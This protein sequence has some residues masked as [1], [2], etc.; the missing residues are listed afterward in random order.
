MYMYTRAKISSLFGIMVSFIVHC[1]QMA[2]IGRHTTVLAMILT[3]Q[4]IVSVTT[5]IRAFN[6]KTFFVSW[7]PYHS[8]VQFGFV[9]QQAAAKLAHHEGMKIE[10]NL[11]LYCH[12]ASLVPAV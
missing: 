2:R 6:L 7:L 10:R 4:L 1:Y 3:R 12:C 9:S 11:L 8:S 5:A